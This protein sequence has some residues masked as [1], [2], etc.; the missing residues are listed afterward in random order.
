MKMQVS[1]IFHFSKMTEEKSKKLHPN[2]IGENLRSFNE[3]EEVLDDRQP[4][5]F[6][7]NHG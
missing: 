7:T 6:K 2:F 1:K 4:F 3:S 5:G